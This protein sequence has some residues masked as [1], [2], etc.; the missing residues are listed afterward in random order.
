MYIIINVQILMAASGSFVFPRAHLLMVEQIADRRI[1]AARKAGIADSNMRTHLFQKQDRKSGKQVV[2]LCNPVRQRI[3]TDGKFSDGECVVTLKQ[4]L[5][6]ICAA[7][8]RGVKSATGVVGDISVGK[9]ENQIRKVDVPQIDVLN[10]E[11]P[12]RAGKKRRATAPLPS[13]ESRA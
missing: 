13:T 7:S 6:D 11:R 5:A 1:F 3:A 2:L 4:M 10:V 9:A 12:V 8:L